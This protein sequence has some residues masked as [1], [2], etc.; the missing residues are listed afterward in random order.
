MRLSRI[1]A[2]VGIFVEQAKKE[3]VL[4][5]LYYIENIE[6]IYDVSG[7]FDIVSIV[8]ASCLE[9]LREVLQR[10]IL[11][12]VGVTS[13]VTNIILRPHKLIKKSLHE[14]IGTGLNK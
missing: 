4:S 13:I 7:E 12:I 8:S 6:E 14:A 5:G 3:D 10:K 9:E 1:L 2:S 11:K